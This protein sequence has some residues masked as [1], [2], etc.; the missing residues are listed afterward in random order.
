MALVAP[1]TMITACANAMDVG[2]APVG[3]A[4]SAWT[5][6]Q[7]TASPPPPDSL[8]PELV[9]AGTFLPYPQGSTA[10]T[11]DPAVV[12]PG[13]TAQVTVTKTPDGMRVGLA[14]SGMVPRRAYGAHLHTEP[15]TASPD[16]AGPHYQ[17]QHDPVKPSVNPS[18]AN[19]KNEIWLDFTADAT[20]TASAVSEQ[21]WTFPPGKSPRSLILHAQQTRTSPGEAGMAGPRVACLTLPAG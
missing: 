2:P 21:D 14:T 13:A 8:P 10:I 15:C 11:Y 6:F 7:G 17:H 5:I 1:L 19:P 3:S 9:A 18:Y 4:T 20:G 12:P 16:A